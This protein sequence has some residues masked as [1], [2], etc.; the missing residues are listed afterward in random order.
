MNDINYYHFIDKIQ[1]NLYIMFVGEIF[2]FLATNGR[3]KEKDARKIFRQVR[4]R[5]KTSIVNVLNNIA[6]KN[7]LPVYNYVT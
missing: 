2:D 4:Q 3:M 5:T 6:M 1:C 7:Q